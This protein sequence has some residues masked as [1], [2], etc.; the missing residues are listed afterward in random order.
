MTARDGCSLDTIN[1]FRLLP[2]K[3]VI[4]DDKYYPDIEYAIKTEIKKNIKFDGYI[5]DI[6][7]IWGKR[8][9]QLGGFDYINFLN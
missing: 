7:N 6:V 3:K 5:S 4:F 9:Y 1:R 2:Y 8:A